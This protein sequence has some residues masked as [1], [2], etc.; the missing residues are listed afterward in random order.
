MPESKKL[1]LVAVTGSYNLCWHP[2]EVKSKFPFRDQQ[3]HRE[4]L[5]CCNGCKRGVTQGRRTPSVM[6]PS[7]GRTKPPLM[8]QQTH[9]PF[10]LYLSM[11][12]N[13]SPAS[14]SRPVN[15]IPHESDIESKLIKPL[16]SP[17]YTAS[18]LA[19]LTKVDHTR[20]AGHGWLASFALMAL[21]IF[22]PGRLSGSR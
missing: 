17:H 14:T 20:P 9:T 2:Y 18:Q 12:P 8:P 16:Q 3:C 5:L 11:C 10:L 7:I 19:P 1:V 21:A 6:L 13:Q 15:H 4:C 22:S